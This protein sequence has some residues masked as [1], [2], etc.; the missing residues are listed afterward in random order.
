[1]DQIR[2]PNINNRDHLVGR[3]T[4][5]WE[6]WQCGGSPFGCP[7]L[8]D[9]PPL[10]YLRGFCPD[11]LVEHYR[12]TTS[13]SAVDP[14]KITMIGYQSARIEYSFS[15]GQWILSDPRLN[16]TARTKASQISYALGKQ[17]WTISGDQYPCSEGG[18]YKGRSQNP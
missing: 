2:N 16:V 6:E 8:F 12:Y 1:M 18:D 5:S 4:R 9:A 7:C 10:I 14:S 13:Q 17:N 3:P 15:L 11:T